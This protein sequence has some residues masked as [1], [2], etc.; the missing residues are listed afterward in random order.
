[1]LWNAAGYLTPVDSMEP[2]MPTPWC[3]SIRLGPLVRALARNWCSDFSRSRNDS[4]SE[5]RAIK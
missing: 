4:A 3:E 5:S 1:M 2:F